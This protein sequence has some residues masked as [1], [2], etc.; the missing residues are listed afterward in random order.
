[1]ST[2]SDGLA[3]LKI[4]RTRRRSSIPLWPFVLGLVVVAGVVA[5]PSVSRHF[6]LPEVA[7]ARS[8]KAGPD[9]KPAEPELSAAGYVVADRQ[10]T[11]ACRA[12]GRLEKLYV[13][14]SQT[15]KTGELIAEVDHR[16]LDALIL[17]VKAERAEIIAEIE[18]LKSLIAQAD[19][20]VA[21]S[22]TPLNTI[23]A[24]IA[25]NQ[26]KLADAKRKWER[27]TKLVEKDAMPGSL[28]EDRLV[29]FKMTEAK[30]VTTQ[31]RREEVEKK[32]LVAKSQLEVARASINVSEARVKSI[33][34]KTNVLET[35]LLD[36]FVYAPFAGKVTE[37][38]AEA[39]EIVAP[40]SV[41]GTMA[42]GSI[43]TIADWNSLQAEVDVA[44]TYITK[45]KD[46]GRAA[47]TVDAVPGRSFPGKVSRILPRA[48]RGKA[49]VQV[50]VDFLERDEN[51]RPEM[52][53][54]VRFIADNAPP[55]TEKGDVKDKFLV[56]KTALQG[57][58]GSHYVWIITDNLARRRTVTVGAVQG[59][60]IEVLTGVSG[61]EA[62]VVR[63][64]EK[65]KDDNQKVLV[66]VN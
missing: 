64:G 25:E 58:A 1:M 40:I 37:K 18:R 19:A 31:R 33:D 56:P 2:T 23:D 62:V 39:G 47:I 10:S 5:A 20:E 42:K 32:I 65:L 30:I 41:G 38:M 21:S 63:G 55:G 12:T 43:V 17:Q 45:V 34:A 51:I 57:A 15:V 11:L 16:E 29:E 50:R 60:T 6:Q 27:D 54:R 53:I 8:V 52:G 44:E 48:N 66:V 36:Y 3:T 46:G 9:G 24:E 49:T 13:T 22:R 14:E 28:A 61:G 4:D 7:V 59:E 26:I 35:Q